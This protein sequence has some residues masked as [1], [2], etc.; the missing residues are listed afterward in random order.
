MEGL[1]LAIEA[2]PGIPVYGYTGF[3]T[4][5]TYYWTNWPFAENAYT[6]PYT[7]WGP[8]KYMTPF[9]EPTGR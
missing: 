4:W 5:D 1:K 2:M 8:L 7:H 3:T 6:Q 9:L